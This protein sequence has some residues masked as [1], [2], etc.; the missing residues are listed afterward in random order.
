MFRKSA[1]RGGLA[2]LAVMT[3]LAA[4]SAGPAAQ[5][6]PL[7]RPQNLSSHTPEFFRDLLAGRVWVFERDGKPSAVWFGPD[8]GLKGCASPKGRRYVPYQ[9]DTRWRI[10]TPNGRSNLE[11]NWATTEGMGYSRRVMIY[12]RE[13]GRLHGE[14]FSPRIRAWY[15]ERDGWIQEGWPAA[16]ARACGGLKLPW[17]V[18]VISAQGSLDIASLRKNAEP[19]TH[20]PGSEFSYPGATG[21]GDSGG[22]PTM[23]LEEVIE[24]R[25]RT[26]GMIRLRNIGGR[27]VGVD[28]PGGVRELWLLD[29]NDDVVDIATIRPI[30]DGSLMH[31]RWEKSGRNATP[32]VGYPV[33]AMSTGRLHPA[34]A[35]MRDLARDGRPVA[36]GGAEYRF[37]EDGR[38]ERG[39]EMGEWWLSRGLVHVRIGGGV[40]TWPWR[41][42]AAETGWK[43]AGR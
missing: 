18:P 14:K 20:H 41:A 6:R 36:A 25:R 31:I 3:T 40:R 13:T 2:A 17:D 4:P 7:L 12:D 15:V 37:A 11:I 1:M 34:F 5:E 32:R 38:I 35:M 29:G 33:P 24:E 21:V 23:T 8:G 22:K 10:G 19:V 26:H 16:F 30:G 9:A 27:T 39:G 42:F 28:R 43:G